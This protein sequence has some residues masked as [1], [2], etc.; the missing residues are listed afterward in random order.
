MGDFKYK[1]YTAEESK[2]YDE[3]ILKIIEGFKNGLSFNEACSAVKVEDKELKGFIEDDA[4]KVIIADMHYAKGISLPEVADALKVS[5]ETTNKA[6]LEMLE[7]VEIATIEGLKQIKHD[8]PTGN[9]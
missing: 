6:S 5:I 8:K 2:I 9:A 7:D 1:E 4:L 3:A